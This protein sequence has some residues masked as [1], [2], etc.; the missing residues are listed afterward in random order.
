MVPVLRSDSDTP[1]VVPITFVLSVDAPPSVQPTGK[2]AVTPDARRATEQLAG[3]LSTSTAPVSVTI[4]PELLDSLST[5]DQAG[6]QALLQDLVAAFGRQ[7]LLSAPYVHMDPSVA[8][9]AAATKEFTAQMRR[10]EDTLSRV[11]RRLPDRRIWFATDPLSPKGAALMRDLGAVVLVQTA[12][13]ASA[14]A[15][16][17]GD[18]SAPDPP[19]VLV[20]T[21]LDE[22][23]TKSSEAP[24]RAAHRLALDLYRRGCP[25][26]PTDPKAKR[27]VRAICES[28]LIPASLRTRA[29]NALAQ[30]STTSSFMSSS[31]CDGVTV[32]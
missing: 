27:K 11:L 29:A 2:S 15:V 24:V 22:A 3:I 4:R 13:A 1:P 10:G 19:S 28:T 21:N 6:D 12:G 14:R 25:T 20:P 30:S 9:N 5:S 7:R 23:L 17:G 16:S 26:D 8:A 18:T 31:D 32:G